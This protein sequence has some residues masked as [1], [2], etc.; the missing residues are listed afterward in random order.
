M[1]VNLIF[2]DFLIVIFY[3]LGVL[4]SIFK[5]VN[6][7]VDLFIYNYKQYKYFNVIS[8]FLFYS[9]VAS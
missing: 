4:K 9:I 6:F 8:F 3:F 2:F 1:A 5:I 7:L